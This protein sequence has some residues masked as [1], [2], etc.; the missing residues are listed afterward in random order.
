M[1]KVSSGAQT[2]LFSPDT[3]KSVY[4]LP[5]NAR[6]RMMMRLESIFSNIHIGL[7]RGTTWDARN[8]LVSLIELCDQLGR[9]DI[10]GELI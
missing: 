1:R 7:E 10:K 9:V 3:L 4:E 8:V 2:T 6:M 5:L